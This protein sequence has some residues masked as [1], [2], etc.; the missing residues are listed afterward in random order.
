MSFSVSG[1]ATSAF[2]TPVPTLGKSLVHTQ[3][4]RWAPLPPETTSQRDSGSRQSLTHGCLHQLLQ[5]LG[6]GSPNWGAQVLVVLEPCGQHSLSFSWSPP[7]GH[8][9]H[10]NPVA[11]GKAEGK[12]G[13]GAE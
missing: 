11:V 8:T 12:V 9:S 10:H 2:T 3:K 1:K 6:I 13:A 4:V 5:S 7:P